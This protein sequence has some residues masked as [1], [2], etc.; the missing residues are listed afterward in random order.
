MPRRINRAKKLRRPWGWT[1]RR[2]GTTSEGYFQHI[3]KA[4]ILAAV[5]NFVPEQVSRL[6]KLKKADIAS[7]AERLA[8]GI[9]WMPAI[10]RGI[11]PQNDLQDVTSEDE[12][13]EVAIAV[14]D[15]QLH[16]NALA[17]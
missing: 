1:W 5:K 16:A 12:T 2:S 14:V 10:F 9:G 11:D 17:A 7:E 3:P 15:D 4:E 8:D 13:V 6:A